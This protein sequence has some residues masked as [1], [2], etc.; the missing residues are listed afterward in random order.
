MSYF[1]GFI[2]LTV[3]AIISANL[4]NMLIRTVIFIAGFII[5]W[6]GSE[7]MIFFFGLFSLMWFIAYG[8][9]IYATKENK[10]TQY[11]ADKYDESQ[12]GK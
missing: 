11:L 10:A 5:C 4:K 9:A 2:A 12:K 6:V 3:I 1:I 7:G 8:T